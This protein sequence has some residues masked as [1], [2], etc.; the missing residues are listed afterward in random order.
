MLVVL[1][2]CH[3]KHE[4]IEA[5][6]TASLINA[7]NSRNEAGITRFDLLQDDE[8]PSRFVLIE[9]YRTSADPA[10]HRETSHYKEWKDNVGDMMAEPRSK[11]AYTN[12]YP[13]DEAW[14]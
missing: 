1:V 4:Y 14:E 10:K 13:P 7:Q 11:T 2:Y 3:V 5:F 6:K 8:D 12:L 9:A